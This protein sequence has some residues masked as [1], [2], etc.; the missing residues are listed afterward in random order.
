MGNYSMSMGGWHNE[1]GQVSTC[2]NTYLG[3]IEL[4]WCFSS[5]LAQDVVSCLASCN[6]ESKR[7]S[8]GVLDCLGQAEQESVKCTVNLHTSFVYSPHSMLLLPR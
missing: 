6:V 5:F 1:Y 7:H 4:W 3:Q 8:T 2:K